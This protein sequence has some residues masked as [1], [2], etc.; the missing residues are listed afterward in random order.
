MNSQHV[1]D[2]HTR[3]N[4]KPPLCNSKKQTSMKKS[5][6]H[7]SLLKNKTWNE[8]INIRKSISF[9]TSLNKQS[10][11]STTAIKK[12]V[13]LNDLLDKDNDVVSC[14][15]KSYIEKI[16]DTSQIVLKANVCEIAKDTLYDIAK[17]NI[18][19]LNQNSCLSVDD[20]QNMVIQHVTH[21]SVFKTIDA[22]QHLLH[23]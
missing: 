10:S 20:V 13:S 8:Q 14:R 17:N 5:T 2:H 16:K 15:N 23:K 7:D 19:Q 9:E 18:Q 11:K 12:S 6:S 1:Q 3:Q 22:V 4:N 21:D